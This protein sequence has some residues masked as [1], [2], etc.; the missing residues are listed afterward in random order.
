MKT[1]IAYLLKLPLYFVSLYGIAALTGFSIW[2]YLPIYTVIG[3]SYEIG[4][5]VRRGEL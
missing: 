1:F 4:E 2:W 3:L 5:M